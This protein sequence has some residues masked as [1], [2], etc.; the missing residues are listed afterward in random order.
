MAKKQHELGYIGNIWVRQNVLEKAGD[1][2]MGHKHLFD[3]VTLLARGKVE[4]LVDGYAP[5]EFE[6]PA[7]ITIKKEYAHKFT[8]LTDDVLW[9]CVF[10]IRDIDGQVTDIIPESSLPYF[11]NNVAD[12]YWEKKQKLEMLSI[13]AEPKNL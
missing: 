5:R 9:Y 1:V 4:V 7:F 2:S 8:A 3:H 10:A 11:I 13:D 6:S 12:D